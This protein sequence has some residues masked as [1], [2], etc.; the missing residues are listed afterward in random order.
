VHLQ[1][2]S[3]SVLYGFMAV[4]ALPSRRRQPKDAEDYRDRGSVE[5]AGPSWR[6]AVGGDGFVGA[7]CL[8]E[9]RG[10]LHREKCACVG[11][12]GGPDSFGVVLLADDITRE[13]SVAMSNCPSARRNLLVDDIASCCRACPHASAQFRNGLAARRNKCKPITAGLHHRG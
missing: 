9:E 4:S 12:Y 11:R 3:C 1:R 2:H 8:R 7:L 6:R 13:Q 5:V 10:F